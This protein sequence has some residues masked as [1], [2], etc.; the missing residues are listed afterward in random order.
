MLEAL[1]TWFESVRFACEVLDVV[2]MR[3][4][5]LAQGGP[6]AA[7]EA[8]RMIAEKFD[9][10]T[11]AEVALLNAL[12]HGEGLLIAAE[13]AYQPVRRRVHDN[14]CRLLRGEDHEAANEFL[15]ASGMAVGA[16]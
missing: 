12:A 6:Q 2:S 13:R 5:R 1:N 3:L 7:A 15:K 10:F 4:M 11:D 16:G 14:S 9:A 8:D